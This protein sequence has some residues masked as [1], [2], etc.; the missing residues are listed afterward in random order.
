L[1]QRLVEAKYPSWIQ[2]VGPSESEGGGSLTCADIVAH[3]VRD[4]RDQMV[5][6]GDRSVEKAFERLGLLRRLVFPEGVP[7]R[8]AKRPAAGRWP[9]PRARSITEP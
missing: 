4:D 8:D 6:T 5:E 7:G 3:E 2:R 9:I 1:A